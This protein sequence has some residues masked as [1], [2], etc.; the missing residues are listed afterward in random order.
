MALAVSRVVDGRGV[1]DR[2]RPGTCPADGPGFSYCGCRSSIAVLYS[3][4]CSLP[5]SLC[6]TPSYPHL[7]PPA[8]A[9]A[10]ADVDACSNPGADALPR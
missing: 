8:N 4:A 5:L 6:Y 3:D 1:A 10:D 2:L 9:L 7:Y